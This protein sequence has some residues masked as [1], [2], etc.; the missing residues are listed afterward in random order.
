MKKAQVLTLLVAVTTS[1]TQ[2]QQK[3]RLSI[4]TGG[5]GGVYYPLGAASRTC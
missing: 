2:A 1:P 5:T 4:A 3:T